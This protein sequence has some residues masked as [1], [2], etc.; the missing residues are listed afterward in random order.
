MSSTGQRIVK[1]LED[2]PSCDFY[3]RSRFLFAAVS[4]HEIWVRDLRSWPL[5]T[6]HDLVTKVMTS[7]DVWGGPR[8]EPCGAH[9]LP[10]I[11]FFGS[12]DSYRQGYFKSWLSHEIKSWGTLSWPTVMAGHD[13]SHRSSWRLETSACLYWNWLIIAQGHL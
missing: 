1:K 9:F 3:P 5:M 4:S 12:Q 6:S 10:Q 8:Q 7:H 2:P 11:F 13:R